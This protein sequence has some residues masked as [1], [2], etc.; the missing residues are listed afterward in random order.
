[1]KI[2]ISRVSGDYHFEASND[3]GNTLHLDGAV[4]IGGTKSGFRP[5]QLLLA[6]VGS[7]SGIDLVSIL[8]KQK[9]VIDEFDIEVKA[10]RETVEQH[11]IWKTIHINFK[12][13][14]EIVPEKALH[15]AQLSMDKYCS[16]AKILEPT[17]R[18]TF[19]VMVNNTL[20]S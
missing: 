7:C 13:N 20:V 12:L 17:A 6:A 18:I 11:S 8:K 15:A 19:H 4:E 3:T 9:Q 10:E 1:M 14:G 16:V 5:M 2:N